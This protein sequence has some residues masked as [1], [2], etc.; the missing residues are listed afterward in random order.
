MDDQANPPINSPQNPPLPTM[1]GTVV[2][3]VQNFAPLYDIPPPEGNKTN[4]VFILIAILLVLAGIVMVTTFYTR[5][6]TNQQGRAIETNK[7]SFQTIQETLTDTLILPLGASGGPTYPAEQKD[8]P[9]RIDCCEPSKAFD[10]N[11]DT[12]WAG[13]PAVNVVGGGWTLYY[14]YGSILPTRT[15]IGIAYY[16][17]YYPASA[18]LSI[19]SDGRT[20]TSLGVV[21]NEP[22]SSF[23]TST[24]FQYLRLTFN[25]LGQSAPYIREITTSVSGRIL[26][27]IPPSLSPTTLPSGTPIPTVPGIP[28]TPVPNISCS[29]CLRQNK[30]YV[31][32][33]GSTYFCAND[34][35]PQS[36][37][38]TCNRCEIPTPTLTPIPATASPVPTTM[39]TQPPAGST[40]Q[41][42][43]FYNVDI[44]TAVAPDETDLT[45]TVGVQTSSLRASASQ[46]GELSREQ[47]RRLHPGD[48]IRIAVVTNNNINIIKARIRVHTGTSPTWRSQDETTSKNTQGE[49]FIDYTIPGRQRNFTIEAQV[50][51]SRDGWK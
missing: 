37:T 3:P 42:L 36:P 47:L 27:P 24:D 28:S 25:P 46:G 29:D 4:K 33:S 34:A 20:W 43:K 44:N 31:C 12:F 51:D 16:H 41:A 10:G 45:P 32:L 39:A 11:I 26:T 9:G 23:T 48:R 7:E 2:P 18:N 1:N 19:S 30:Q 49:F 38:A 22:G 15:T 13:D 8:P 21:P 14:N 17:G 6:R 35:L 50:F 5:Y 40:C